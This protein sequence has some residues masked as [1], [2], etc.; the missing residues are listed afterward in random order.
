M[1]QGSFQQTGGAL[2][3]A[4]TGQGVFSVIQGDQVEKPFFTRGGSFNFKAYTLQGSGP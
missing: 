2:D 4:I 1:S 3:L